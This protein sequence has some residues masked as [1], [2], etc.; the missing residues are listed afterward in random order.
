MVRG[1]ENGATLSQVPSTVISHLSTGDHAVDE[2]TFQSTLKYIFKF[3]EKVRIV[4]VTNVTNA[5]RNR[6]AGETS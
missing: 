6:V 4:T 1:S 2:E 5:D 3:I